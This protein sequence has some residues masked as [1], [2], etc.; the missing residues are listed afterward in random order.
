[1]PTIRLRKMRLVPPDPPKY[2]KRQVKREIFSFFVAGPASAHGWPESLL[3]RVKSV[4]GNIPTIH[5]RH[6]QVVASSAQKRSGALQ[7]SKIFPVDLWEATRACSIRFDLVISQLG[8]WLRAMEEAS[9]QSGSRLLSHPPTRSIIC[10][11]SGIVLCM[12]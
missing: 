5:L 1:M 6:Q 11:F 3:N 8:V 9:H 4:L 2:E 12:G 10:P 7:I